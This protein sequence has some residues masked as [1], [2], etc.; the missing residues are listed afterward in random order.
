MPQASGT[1]AHSGYIAGEMM[2]M[3][4]VLGLLDLPRAEFA[5]LA[6]CVHRWAC[7]PTDPK[8]AAR[9]VVFGLP[10][11]PD[12]P[13]IRRILQST[14][15]LP[16]AYCER[17]TERRD[18]VELLTA[19]PDLTAERIELDEQPDPDESFDWH[20]IDAFIR[21][22]LTNVSTPAA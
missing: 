20:P 4:T 12:L 5:E 16:F 7:D 18:T 11:G 22:G 2:L 19:D 13:A 14:A 10:N 8:S 21:A 3:E 9:A 6:T 17:R 15:S 1:L